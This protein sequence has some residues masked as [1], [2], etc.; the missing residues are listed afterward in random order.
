MEFNEVISILFDVN[1]IFIFLSLLYFAYQIVTKRNTLSKTVIRSSYLLIIGGVAYALAEFFTEYWALLT[2]ILIATLLYL[3]FSL[4]KRE[5]LGV[6]TA[7]ISAF[8]LVIYYYL[9]FTPY[10]NTFIH[11]LTVIGAVIIA[12]IISVILYFRNRS[13]V[14][15][16]IMGILVIRFFMG[17]FAS[18]YPSSAE[19][20]SM[21]S[22][23]VASFFVALYVSVFRRKFVAYTALFV[24]MGLIGGITAIIVS[25]ATGILTATIYFVAEAFAIVAIG[26][27]VVYFLRDYEENFSI[28]SLLF[29]SAFVL[30]IFLALTDM[31]E[32]LLYDIVRYLPPEIIYLNWALIMVALLAALFLTGALISLSGKTRVLFV[33]SLFASSITTYVA[34]ITLGANEENV[35]QTLAYVIAVLFVISVI[36]LIYIE[37]KLLKFGA[38]GPAFRFFGYFLAALLYTVGEVTYATL[39]FLE[40]GLIIFISGI[41]FLITSPVLTAYIRG[42]FKHEHD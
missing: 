36:A 32:T 3:E 9:F 31:L 30:I 27:N 15:F 13:F 19:L 8:L 18:M 23:V 39:T 29:T 26:L 17:L 21:F 37:K 11:I 22:L 14:F 6:I 25:I 40:T 7:I 38:K 34:T 28:N 2:I 4:I 10:A 1:V 16:S 24:S 35:V 42:R 5:I 12:T 20:I 41:I 33:F